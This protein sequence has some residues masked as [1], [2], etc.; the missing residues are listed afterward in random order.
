MTSEYRGIRDRLITFGAESRLGDLADEAVQLGRQ[1]LVRETD[2]TFKRFVDA[3]NDCFVANKLLIDQWNAHMALHNMGASQHAELRRVSRALAARHDAL[4][5]VS[6]RLEEFVASVQR[7]QVGLQF[8]KVVAADASAAARGIIDTTIKTENEAVSKAR[9]E[10][11][12]TREHFNR[13]ASGMATQI[14][15]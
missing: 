13:N 4:A 12:K 15:A 11:R 9:E 3:D 2:R 7:E 14:G 10:F 5:V 1:R 8:L 6:E